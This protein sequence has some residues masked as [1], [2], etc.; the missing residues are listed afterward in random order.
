MKLRFGIDPAGRDAI[1]ARL[2]EGCE[3][4]P[5]GRGL[6]YVYLDTP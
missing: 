3:E 6:S 2:D 5:I 1:R 4:P